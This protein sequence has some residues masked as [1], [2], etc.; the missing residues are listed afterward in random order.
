MLY[1]C[2]DC[3]W[4]A[5]FDSGMRIICLHK[6]LPPNEVCKY[7]SIG[8][9][10]ASRCKGF[11]EDWYIDLHEFSSKDFTTAELYSEEKYG[12]V[13]YAGIRDW[14]ESEIELRKKINKTTILSYFVDTK[15]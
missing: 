9:E 7:L 15:M 11:D 4:C 14:C 12:E 6:N 8:T 5:N 10:D 1:E 2:T 3:K 13:T